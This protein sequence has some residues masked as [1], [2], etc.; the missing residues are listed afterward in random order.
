VLAYL[1]VL[2]A[3]VLFVALSG[4]KIAQS[5]LNSVFSASGLWVAIAVI[6]V[7][8]AYVAPSPVARAK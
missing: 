7:G 4:N 3:V 6:L 2:F 5:Y 1:A 8:A